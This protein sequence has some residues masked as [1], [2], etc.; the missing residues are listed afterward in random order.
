MGRNTASYKVTP[1]NYQEDLVL[2]LPPGTYQADWVDAATGS[3]IR[4]DK[5]THEGGSR[6]IATP[7]HA[8]DIALRIKRG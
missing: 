1:G 6:T 7:T 2:N 8:V 5:F 3:I 4:T